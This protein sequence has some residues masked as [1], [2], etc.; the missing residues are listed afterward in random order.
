MVLGI[1]GVV[2]VWI[3]FFGIVP[4]ILATVF[5]Y[6]GRSKS[7]S[8]GRAGDGMGM[9]GII[10]GWIVIGLTVLVIVI[11]AVALGNAVDN[12]DYYY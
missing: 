10:L 2:F 8:M 1:V 11:W 5:G 9:A 6:V 4:G 12:N 3:P 7:R